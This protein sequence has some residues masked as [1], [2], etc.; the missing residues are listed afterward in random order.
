MQTSAQPLMKH[1]FLHGRKVGARLWRE[2][3]VP[4]CIWWLPLK[5]DDEVCQGILYPN[6]GSSLCFFYFLL[7]IKAVGNTRETHSG[8]DMNCL[9]FNIS[10]IYILPFRFSV[11]CLAISC[12]TPCIFFKKRLNPLWLVANRST[13]LWKHHYSIFGWP[14]FDLGGQWNIKLIAMETSVMANYHQVHSFHLIKESEI[15]KLL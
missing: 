14:P 2:K 13:S 3:R 12:P 8:W 15:W 10:F 1:S 6:I 11:L 4:L 5:L 7:D 9:F